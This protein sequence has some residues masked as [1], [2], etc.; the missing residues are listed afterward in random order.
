MV[1]KIL[2]PF[3]LALAC[4]FLLTACGSSDNT[5]TTNNTSTTT[6]ANKTTTTTS[7]TTTST[8]TTTS[9]PTTTAAGDKI[10]VPECDYYLAKMETC[11]GKIPAAAKEQYDKA[12]ETTKKAW[13]DAAA[14]PQGKAGLAAGCNQAIETAKT[15][16]KSF[17]CEF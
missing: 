9:S 12:M 11:L 15:S 5:A 8:P 4:A 2:A 1:K 10:G 6:N 13:R 14:T 3:A 16:M 7:P 17:N